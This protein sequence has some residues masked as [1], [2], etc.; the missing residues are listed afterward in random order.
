MPTFFVPR[1]T[2]PEQANE[3]YASMRMQNYYGDDKPGRLSRIVFEHGAR[4]FI[5]QVGRELS[6]FPYG[7]GEVHAIIETTNVCTIH[8]ASTESFPSRPIAVYPRRIRSRQY[9]DDY[10]AAE[11]ATVPPKRQ[12]KGGSHEAASPFPPVP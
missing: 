7:S 1:T 9:F 3:A 8:V 2:S 11:G 5:A 12:E 10:S 4:L 6:D